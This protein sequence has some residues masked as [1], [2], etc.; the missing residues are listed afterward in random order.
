MPFAHG[1]E[2]NAL[3]LE[4]SDGPELS[5]TWSWPSGLLSEEAVRRSCP[6]LVRGVKGLGGSHR[7]ARRRGHIPSDFPLVTLCQGEIEGLEVSYPNFEDVLPLSPLQEGL[8]SMLFTIRRGPDLYTVQVVLG[9]EGALDSQGLQDAAEA[10]F[11]RHANL[12]ASFVHEGLSQPV[13]VILCRGGLPWRKSISAGLEVDGAVRGALGSVADPRA[14]LAL[15]AWLCALLRFSLIRLAADRHRLLLSNHHL[16]MDGWSLPVLVRELFVL[17]GHGGRKAALQR[18]TPS[19]TIWAGSPRRIARP[20]RPSG[21]GRSKA[22]RSRPG[23]QRLSRGGGS[24]S[25]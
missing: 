7:T 18:V 8:S 10:L 2:V 6:G 23:W 9:L 19:G 11:E 13:Q 15:R 14:R 20:P 4:R 22:W 17:Y 5:A 1:L 12:R 21:R 16:L 3:T 25:S 24:G